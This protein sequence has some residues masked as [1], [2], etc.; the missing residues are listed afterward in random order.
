M[1]I[2]RYVRIF[3]KNPDDELVHKRTNA[4]SS[5]VKTYKAIT[6]V[7]DL[8]QLASDL[9][10]A[11]AKRG[12]LPDSRIDEIEAAIREES[13]SFVR[14][15]EDLQM[16]VCSMMAV[17]QLLKEAKPS[18]DVWSRSDVIAIGLWSG[19]SFQTPRSEERF[20]ALRQD[21]LGEAR[22]LVLASAEKARRRQPVNSLTSENGE[23]TNADDEESGGFE[24][25]AEEAIGA[26]RANAALDREEL[27]V[28]WWTFAGWS[29]I[30]EKPFAGLDEVA[31]GVLYGIEM[32]GLL[33]RMPGE[34]H[35]QL[36][37]HQ[38]RVNPS[39]TMEEVV[40]ILAGERP[41]IV[42]KYENNNLL[43]G[44]EPIFPL[45]SALTAG[46]PRSKSSLT[47]SLSAADWSLR[48]LLESSILHVGSL[49]RALV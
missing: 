9:T 21:L 28:L 27:D 49:P 24:T 29:R 31:A 16:L 13:S 36:V 43:T 7:A 3:E 35:K 37:M 20:D 15:K 18:S 11:V 26:L 30:A 23:S 19:L 1:D 44:R 17:L 33:R 4:I 32:S 48:A 25:N 39:R 5:L 6:T 42:L 46:K 45:L 47:K 14:D 8:L 40:E 10:K 12:T 41:K 22:R 34:Q 38:I 2:A